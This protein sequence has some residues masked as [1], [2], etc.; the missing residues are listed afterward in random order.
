MPVTESKPIELE[1]V[2]LATGQVLTKKKGYV[3]ATAEQVKA[4]G[5]TFWADKLAKAGY[6]P[7][8][9]VL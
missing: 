8:S 4:A 3:I 6:K 7:D 2:T 9:E 5:E 1:M